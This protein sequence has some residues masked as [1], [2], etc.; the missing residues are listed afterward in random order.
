[1]TLVHQLMPCM[2]LGSLLLIA[3]AILTGM[4]LSLAELLPGWR[5]RLS[6]GICALSVIAILIRL[7]PG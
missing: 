5:S 7:R 2:K 6:A 1:M 4:L 3:G